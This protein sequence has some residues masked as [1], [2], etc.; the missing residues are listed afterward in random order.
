MSTILVKELIV[1]LQAHD[2]GMDQNRISVEKVDQAL[3]TKL[4]IRDDGQRSNS[5][6]MAT[7]DGYQRSRG[8]ILS[9]EDMKSQIN[10]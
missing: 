6:G 8:E 9:T 10:K 3:Q 7:M 4:S 5:K 2:Q 1:S